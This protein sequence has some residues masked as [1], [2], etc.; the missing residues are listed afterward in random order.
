[1]TVTMSRE[2]W[3]MGLRKSCKPVGECIEWQGP[4]MGKTPL[5]YCPAGY[6]WEGSTQSRQSARSVL[7]SLANGRRL[8]QHSVIRMRCNNYRCVHED[9]FY[10]I[11]RTH[12]AKE[13]SKRGE[14]QTKRRK[15]A[16][17]R[18]ARQRA[19]LTQEDVYAIRASH[20]SSRVEAKKYDV[21]SAT[22][23]AVRRGRLWADVIVG[24]SVFNWGGAL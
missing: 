4:Y 12:Q 5:V 7:F 24:A 23:N 9:H 2:K 21:S 15:V 3:L 14:L 18:Q 17:T 1:M 11:P 8:S 22:I 10:I 13:Q 16:V 20:D 19:K 6:A